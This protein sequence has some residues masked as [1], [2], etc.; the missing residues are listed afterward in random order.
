[1]DHMTLKDAEWK[2]DPEPISLLPLFLF[3][4][5]VGFIFLSV[6]LIMLFFYSKHSQGFSP[7]SEQLWYLRH[8][9]CCLPCLPFFS[10]LI[11]YYCTT[12]PSCSSHTGFF[13]IPKQDKTCS[14]HGPLLSLFTMPGKLFPQWLLPHLQISASHLLSKAFL[15][16]PCAHSYRKLPSYAPASFTY[17]ALSPSKFTSIYFFFFPLATLPEGQKL[18]EG[19]VFG[20][21]VHCIHHGRHIFFFFE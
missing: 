15:I 6:F 14:H 16:S 3:H 8:S 5:A 4:K 13:A 11:S 1:M 21:S 12:C 7:P 20:H 18:L 2:K 10:D 9:L 19:S 17:I